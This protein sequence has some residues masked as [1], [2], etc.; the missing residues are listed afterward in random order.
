MFCRLRKFLGCLRYTYILLQTLHKRQRNQNIR[1]VCVYW[2]LIR[3]V[4]RET[5]YSVFTVVYFFY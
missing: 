2:T 5:F 1:C 3:E 4:E